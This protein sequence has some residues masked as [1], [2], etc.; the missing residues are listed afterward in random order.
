[1]FKGNRQFGPDFMETGDLI[2]DGLEL[3]SRFTWE[4]AHQDVIG[5]SPPFG[6]GPDS[7][8]VFTFCGDSGYTGMSSVVNAPGTDGTVRWAGC[9]LNSRKVIMD[10]TDYPPEGKRI[11]VEEWCNLKIPLIPATGLNHGSIL[12]SPTDALVDQVARALTVCSEDEFNAWL[13]AVE[14]E[15]AEK[16]AAMGRWQQ[17]VIRAVD[18][19]GDPITE[20]NFQLY[21]KEQ[22]EAVAAASGGGGD[23]GG[24]TEKQLNFPMDVHTYAGDK[25]LRCFHVQ[26]DQ[27]K[28]GGELIEPGSITDGLFLRIMASSG[29]EKVGYSGFGG[30]EDGW[31]AELDISELLTA[32]GARFFYPFTTTLLEIRLSRDPLP[33]MG[34][35]NVL[36]FTEGTA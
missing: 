30:S 11:R 34:K 3:G 31:A 1:M 17:F 32:K 24:G 8:Y 7:P 9:A 26:L 18:D 22:K 16:T 6:N 28:L 2:L 10:L 5:P 4:L 13:T 12:S 19:R 33:L 23:G 14:A 35:N 15:T 21:V 27:L 36:W 25:S 20:Y 29:S